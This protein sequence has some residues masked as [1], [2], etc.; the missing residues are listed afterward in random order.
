MEIEAEAWLATQIAHQICAGKGR[1]ASGILYGNADP[2]R[3]TCPGPHVLIDI[4]GP[5]PGWAVYADPVQLAL[6]KALIGGSMPDG[7]EIRND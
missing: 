2:F 6:L 1:V 5:E 4:S 3:E 7:W